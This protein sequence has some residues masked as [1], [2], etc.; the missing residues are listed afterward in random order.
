MASIVSVGV[1]VD[2]PVDMLA[3]LRV[4]IM[5]SPLRERWWHYVVA[6]CISVSQIY[7][8]V[9]NLLSLGIDRGTGRIP[10]PAPLEDVQRYVLRVVARFPPTPFTVLVSTLVR[11]SPSVLSRDLLVNAFRIPGRVAGE[12]LGFAAVFSDAHEH[13]DSVLRAVHSN[14]SVEN[15]LE[16]S[17]LLRRSQRNVEHNITVLRDAGFVLEEIIANTRADY[18]N[19]A[20]E[21]AYSYLNEHGL[22]A[23]CLDEED[24]ADGVAADGVAADGDAAD[25]DAADGDAADGDAAD[26]DAAVGVAADEEEGGPY[27]IPVDVPDTITR[28]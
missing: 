26:G 23:E 27:V 15:I 2:E 8:G 4:A 19:A 1:P 28:R 14:E 6:R 13:A 10:L 3:I 12:L 17:R 16:L 5:L 9:A 22:G 25:G 18:I 11:A 24:A 20:L 21:E 7:A